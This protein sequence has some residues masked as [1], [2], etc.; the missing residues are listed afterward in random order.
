ME[1]EEN[2]GLINKKAS[3]DQCVSSWLILGQFSFELSHYS[4]S[5]LEAQSFLGALLESV[6]YLD[7]WSKK[8]KEEQERT[9]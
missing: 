3:Q 8:A 6:A 4:L 2:R 9:S 5:L 7:F 1:N